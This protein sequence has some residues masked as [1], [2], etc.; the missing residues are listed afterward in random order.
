MYVT[1]SADDRVLP[2]RD[3]FTLKNLRL[4]YRMDPMLNTVL[5]FPAI[6]KASLIKSLVNTRLSAS[7][8]SIDPNSS[9]SPGL[10]E[11]IVISSKGADEW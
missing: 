9:D 10:V 3:V 8:P 7:G 4:L 2:Y 6:S 1:L 5:L 11:L